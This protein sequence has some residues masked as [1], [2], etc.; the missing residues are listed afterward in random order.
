MTVSGGDFGGTVSGGDSG[1]VSSPFPVLTEYNITQLLDIDYS[2][3]YNAVY[4]A[5]FDAIDTYSQSVTDGQ[6]INS[7]ALTYFQGILENQVFPVDYVIY[8]GNSYVYGNSTR[9]EYCMA[10]GDLELSGTHFSGTGTVVTMRVSGYNSVN[11]AYDQSVSLDAPMYY[12][13][14]N[15]GDYSGVVSYNWIGFLILVCLFT[16]GLVWFLKRFMRLLF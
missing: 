8:V 1:P 5:S 4:G 3:I 13:R 9:Y 10:Y 15:L 6:S 7:T 14:S 16:G 2:A 11:Y 12:S